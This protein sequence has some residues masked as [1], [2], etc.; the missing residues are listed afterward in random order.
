MKGGDLLRDGASRV[1]LA[2]MAD[3]SNGLAVWQ[4]GRDQGFAKMEMHLVERLGGLRG[5]D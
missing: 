3:A 5:V 4:K 2:G 1:V